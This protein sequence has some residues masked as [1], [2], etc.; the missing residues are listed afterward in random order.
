MKAI[1]P[2][3]ERGNFSRQRFLSTASYAEFTQDAAVVQFE[4]R[5]LILQKLYHY[6]LPTKHTKH[7]NC[8]PRPAGEG[9]GENDDL[10]G[11]GKLKKVPFV[12][13]VSLVGMPLPITVPLP[14]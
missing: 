14:K 1:T 3:N 12:C 2:V 6:R 7:T 4:P 13:F 10:A 9:L 11:G 5:F 8:N